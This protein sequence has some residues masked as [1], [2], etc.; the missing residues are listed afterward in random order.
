[1]GRLL[2]KVLKKVETKGSSDPV[3]VFIRTYHA[4]MTTYGWIPLKEYLEL[5][6]SL[7]NA[8]VQEIIKDNPPPK[9]KGTGKSFKRK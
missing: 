6:Q 5:P 7:V 3:Y 8:L 4:L 9:K 2:D 1:M